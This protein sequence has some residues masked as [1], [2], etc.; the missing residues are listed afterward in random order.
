MPIKS[1]ILPTLQLCSPIG[2]SPKRC[3]PMHRHYLLCLPASLAHHRSL[4]ANA[5]LA[6]FFL[7]L[8]VPSCHR[9]CQG[10]PPP[11]PNHVLGASTSS[12]SSSFASGTSF[13]VGTV[14]A[15]TITIADLW[16]WTSHA[17]LSSLLSISPAI[18][19]YLHWCCLLR[20]RNIWAIRLGCRHR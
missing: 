9:T 15:F 17:L 10:V 7:R 2:S 13:I 19:C 12:L 16:P 5:T 6:V 20:H 14:D 18:R 8:V 3:L 1:L 4:L 11:L